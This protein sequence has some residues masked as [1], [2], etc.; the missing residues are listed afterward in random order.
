MDRFNKQSWSPR[1]LFKLYFCHVIG[2]IWSR[3][4]CHVSV[5]PVPVFQAITGFYIIAVFSI[6]F[7]EAAA[8]YPLIAFVYW[9]DMF[10][11]LMILRRP[12][13]PISENTKTF[14][15]TRSCV[16]T[17]SLT[18][19]S[20]SEPDLQVSLCHVLSHKGER[21]VMTILC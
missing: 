10:F 2:I 19:F 6:F 16:S 15:A 1:T 12:I 21:H 17:L 18:H 5:F 13:K 14:L 7:R 8:F 11:M 3:S 9:V 4:Q 20:V